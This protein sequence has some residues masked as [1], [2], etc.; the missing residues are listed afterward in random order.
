MSIN[1]FTDNSNKALL[2][3]ILQE[4][5]DKIDQNDYSTFKNFFEIHIETL[6][7]NMEKNNNNE[8]IEKNKFFIQDT[9]ALIR[10]NQWKYKYNKQPYTSDEVKEQNMNEFE[11]RFVQRQKEFSN[12]I[13]IKKPE[14]LSFE[15]NN[16]D[17]NQDINVQLERMQR[18]REIE[19]DFNTQNENISGKKIQILEDEIPKKK[20]TFNNLID[21]I[22]TEENILQDTTQI[23]FINDIKEDISFIKEEMTQLKNT[24]N[25]LLNRDN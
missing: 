15:D 24:M 6:N 14:E 17:F 23:D 21:S 18:E 11:K 16:S 7:K 4:S 13:N 8:L 22:E 12:L 9:L 20:V 5:F 19:I 25:L 10:N 2:W 3:E 1:I